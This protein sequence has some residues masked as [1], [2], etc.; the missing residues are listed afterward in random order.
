[1]TSLIARYGQAAGLIIALLALVVIFSILGNGFFS[2]RT[3]ISISNQIPDLTFVAVG[4]TLVLIAG[5]I[6]LSVGSLLA[7]CSAVLGIAMVDADLGLSIAIVLAAITGIVCGLVSG[8]ITVFTGVPAFIV[9][10]GMLEIARGLA[11]LVSD[12][13]TQYIGES[14]EI[15]AYPLPGLGISA[16]Y[17]AALGV[18]ILGHVLL[19]RTVFGRYLIAIGTNEDTVHMAGI[20]PR[21]YRIAVFALSGFLCALAALSQSARLGS[22]DPNA[23]IGLE[24]SAIAAAVIGGTSLMGGRGSVAMTFVGVLVIS[25]LQTGLASVGADEPSKRIIT[26]AVIV[27]A[28]LVDVWRNRNE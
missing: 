18:V 25:V 2:M 14:I 26:G 27:V 24:L 15:V 12:S 20:N 10:L 4:M 5:G 23:A 1:V 16:A 28:A 21:P 19:T 22:A 13:Q 17:V 7:L 8:S 9:T 6:D 3:L 11:Y